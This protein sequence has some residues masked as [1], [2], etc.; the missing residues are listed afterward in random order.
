MADEPAQGEQTDELNAFIDARVTAALAAA[1]ANEPAEPPAPAKAK[2]G[3]P[4]PP[5]AAAA[6]RDTIDAAVSKAVDAA[7]SRR[8]SDDAVSY[9]TGQVD[10][11][12][13]KLGAVPGP[14]KPGW[15]SLLVG[16]WRP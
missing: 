6:D 5:A 10:E 2:R 11:L 7:L 4:A 3:E 16:L 15:G 8:D 12:K 13:A 1:G 14:R 9:L